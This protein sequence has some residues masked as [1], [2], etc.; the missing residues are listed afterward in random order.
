M[1]KRKRVDVDC[2]VRAAWE[3]VILRI[4]WVSFGTLTCRQ[5]RLPDEEA[6]KRF[7]RFIRH[8]RRIAGVPPSWYACLEY[9]DRGSPHFQVLLAGI[10]PGLEA[11]LGSLWQGNVELE[12]FDTTIRRRGVAYVTKMIPFDGDALCGGPIFPGTRSPS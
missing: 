8:S 2:G 10:A 3:E 12:P 6:W 5:A 4:Q 1:R 11:A 9:Q 7:N